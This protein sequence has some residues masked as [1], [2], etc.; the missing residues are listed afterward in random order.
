MTGRAQ[1]FGGDGGALCVGFAAI[2][3]L[4]GKAK[5]KGEDER[6]AAGEADEVIQREGCGG[7]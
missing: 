2:R 7:G 5:E 6:D 4:A 1:E 3:A